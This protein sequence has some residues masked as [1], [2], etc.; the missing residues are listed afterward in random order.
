MIK[1]FLCLKI[2]SQPQITVL[3]APEILC[4]CFL[5]T[6]LLSWNSLT[7]FVFQLSATSKGSPR[8]PTRAPPSS[9][10]V[11]LQ[12]LLSAVSLKLLPFWTSNAQNWFS[13]VEGQFHTR[14]ITSSITKYYY[15]IQSFNQELSAQFSDIV[16]SPP[17]S[18]PYETLKARVLRQYTLTNFQRV[19][20]MLNLPLSSDERP[21]TLV[22]KMLAAMPPGYKPDFL[23]NSL[24]LRRLPSK[25]W[26]HL[27]KKVDGDPCE[28][29]IEA[30]KLWQDKVVSVHNLTSTEQHP[31]E[32]W[33]QH[34][35][36]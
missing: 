29:V 11:D 31:P 25:I 26:V 18:E 27:L 9:G 34:K 1:I 30:D 4:P 36:V 6:D 2:K 23:F 16:G 28:L 32:F 12:L 20:A 24:F 8:W 3:Q 10:T 5:Q 35:Q 19:E 21:S 14:G 13:N 15:C 22:N 33:K 7:V 17:P